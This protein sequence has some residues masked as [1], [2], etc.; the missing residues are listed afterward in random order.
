MW[1]LLTIS[2][3]EQPCAS[4]SAPHL[5]YSV[6]LILTFTQCKALLSPFNMQE[7]PA[8]EWLENLPNANVLFFSF[9]VCFQTL[10]CLQMSSSRAL[11]QD[12]K[13]LRFNSK[14]LQSTGSVQRNFWMEHVYVCVQRKC[15]HQSCL[16]WSLEPSK[17]QTNKKNAKIIKNILS[18][19]L[20]NEEILRAGTEREATQTRMLDM[21]SGWIAGS[22]KWKEG[23]FPGPGWWACCRKQI[24]PKRWLNWLWVGERN[25]IKSDSLHCPRKNDRPQ[26]GN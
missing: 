3:W 4:H 25:E 11:S 14:D 24:E 18:E 22:W 20:R 6:L 9:L 15:R 10:V 12:L 19:K 13:L 5:T 1:L 2:Y 23:I 16:Y 17:N 26:W 21:K 7:Y 8:S